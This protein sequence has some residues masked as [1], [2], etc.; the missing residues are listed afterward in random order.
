MILVTGATGHIGNVLVRRLVES[1][2][3]VRVFL[4]P[5][6]NTQSLTGLE[7]DIVEG[8]VLEYSTV[9]KA[10]QDVKT[11]FHLA[12]LISILPDSNPLV[13]LVNV[14]GT[15]NVIWA[16]LENGVARMVYTSSI[17]AFE[18]IPHGEK[19]S[20]DSIINPAK[21]VAAYDR[22]KAEATLA[23]Q[24]AVEHLGLN[25]VIVCPTGVIG[26]FDYNQSEMGCLIRGWMKKRINFLINGSYDFVDVRDVADGLIQAWQRGKVGERYILNGEQIQIPAILKLVKQVANHTSLDIVVPTSL[27]RFMVKFTPWYYHLSGTIPRLTSYSIDTLKSNSA[28]EPQKTRKALAFHPRPLL[29]TITDTVHWWQRQAQG[30][31]LNP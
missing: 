26:P 29:Q 21:A 10:F 22:S 8:N 19:I 24:H 30:K 18:P 1:G 7:I 13:H 3:S 4:L 6:E 15:K 20:E 23:V 14:L 17:H 9:K 16:A 2:E 31:L 25:A 12:G 11:V 27:A 28:I 5:G